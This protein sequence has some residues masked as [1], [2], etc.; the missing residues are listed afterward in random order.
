[1]KALNGYQ[2]SRLCPKVFG[3]K[4]FVRIKIMT[5]NKNDWLKKDHSNKFIAGKLIY[6]MQF[7]LITS[8]KKKTFNSVSKKLCKRFYAKL[9]L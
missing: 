7:P 1:L 2:N 9:C 8:A 4:A 5:A 6:N 3:N